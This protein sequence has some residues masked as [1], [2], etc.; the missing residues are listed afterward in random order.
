MLRHLAVAAWRNLLANRVQS[1]IAIM[2]LVLPLASPALAA[3]IAG[4]W[5]T[6]LRGGR[7]VMRVSGS[8]T[9]GWQATSYAI[10]KWPDVIFVDPLAFDGTQV[11][12]SIARLRASFAGTLGTD[13][14]TLTGTWTDVERLPLEYRRA[15]PGSA[16]LV[17]TSPHR[18]RSV[19]TD[20]GIRIEVLDW[21]GEGRPL[22]FIPD[23]GDSAH[24]F[25]S[26][27]PELAANFQIYGIS[28]RPAGNFSAT[29]LGDDV[30][31]V[32]T[33]LKLERPILVGHGFAAAELNSIAGR[34]PEKIAGLIY[35]DADADQILAAQLKSTDVPVLAIFATSQSK[36]LQPSKPV[37]QQQLE[38]SRDA[39]MKVLQT[40]SKRVRVVKLSAQH[41]LWQT[42][43]SGVIF[44]LKKFVNALPK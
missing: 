40:G 15:S 5:Q 19:T 13:G 6:T 35:L 23:V 30:L 37:S 28:R 31:A 39:Q 11:R 9:D 38:N 12:F 17:D 7:I 3:D 14:G 18:S 8:E 34:Y 44:E 27:V 36:D 32:M 21:G 41:Y 43:A 24:V 22:I 1:A 10:D 4:T 33:A 25:D 26:F 42:N 29:R 2:L 20:D 16:W